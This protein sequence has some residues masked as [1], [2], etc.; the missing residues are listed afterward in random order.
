M[1]SSVDTQLLERFYPLNML[2]AED[3]QK[4]IKD[5]ELNNANAG[6]VLLKQQDITD[7]FFHYLVTGELEVRVTFNDRRKYCDSDSDINYPLEELLKDG[8]L[9]RC[10]TD[11]RYLKVSR[12]LYDLL[13]ANRQSSEIV[14]VHMEDDAP[15]LEDVLIDDSFEEDW[16][17]NFLSSALASKLDAAT[18]HQLYVRLE[19][20][21]VA[22]GSEVVRK[23]SDGDY[24]YILKS[25]NAEVITDLDGPFKGEHI[26]LQP[27]SYFGDEALISDTKRNATVMMTSDGVLGRLDKEAFDQLIRQSLIQSGSETDNSQLLDVRLLPEFRHDGPENALNIPV[28][29]LRVKMRELDHSKS[30]LVT[31][32]GGRRSELAVYLMRQAGFD[33]YL[34]SGAGAR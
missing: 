3:L 10:L 14:V 16:T 1:P 19:D 11:C 31:A 24:F 27:G 6:S 23:D 9:V 20:I 2:P 33:A 32:H 17:H 15:A 30:Y 26:E 29:Q 5:S 25:G 12:D 21:E 18:M 22:E 4:L 13:I 8:G 34:L 28:C 7:Q